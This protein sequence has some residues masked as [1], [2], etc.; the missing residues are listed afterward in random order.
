ME[1]KKILIVEDENIIA[2]DLQIILVE[3]GYHVPYIAANSQAALKYAAELQPDLILMD[4]MIQGPVDGIVTAQIINDIYDIPI[5]FLSAYS[6]GKT[7]ERAKKAG[8]YGYLLKPY[9]DRELLIAMEF[10]IQKASVERILKKSNQLFKSAVCCLEPVAIVV[11]QSGDIT[12][13]SEQARHLFGW[14]IDELPNMAIRELIQNYDE[15]INQ[16]QDSYNAVFN[17]KH[18]G[19]IN[20]SFRMQRLDD[21]KNNFIGYLIY[22]S[23]PQ[24]VKADWVG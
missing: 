16:K 12:L 19:P 24:V 14:Q 6:D 20:L 7:L 18:S 9:D 15:L 8:S 11:N 1:Q 2:Q 21:N 10:S 5:V 13:I 4:V 3:A 23:S 22:V 17:S